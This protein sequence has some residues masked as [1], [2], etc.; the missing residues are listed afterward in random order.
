MGRAY[1]KSGKL[2]EAIQA[3]Q[4]AVAQDKNSRPGIDAAF[5]LKHLKEKD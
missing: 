3:Y 1:E 4:K 2:K 5:Q